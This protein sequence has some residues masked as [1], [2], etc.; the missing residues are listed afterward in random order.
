MSSE[1]ATSGLARKSRRFDG[2][3]QHVQRLLVGVELRPPA[4]LVGYAGEFAGRLH[5]RTGGE[6]DLGRHFERLD[7]TR[8]RRSPDHEVPGRRAARHAHPPPK[9]WIS[10]EAWS[11][12]GRPPRGATAAHDGRGGRST[13][14]LAA[15]VALP[16]RRALLGVPSSSIEIEPA[17]VHGVAA[18]QATGDLAI[19]DCTHRAG[20]VETAPGAR[21]RRAGRW[22]RASRAKRPPGDAAPAAAVPPAPRRPPPSAVR[23]SPTRRP[24]HR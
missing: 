23:A 20:H 4:A 6:V 3:G 9:I 24:A 21:R 11:L 13:A 1:I 14:R 8:W 10:A 16:P 5:Q 7:R 19:D 18:D 2:A 17:S 22:F 12:A 15:T